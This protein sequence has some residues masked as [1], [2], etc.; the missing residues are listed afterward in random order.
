MSNPINPAALER[1]EE[2]IH[3]VYI[4]I[5]CVLNHALDKSLPEELWIGAISKLSGI[6]EDK[7]KSV[8]KVCREKYLRRSM[9]MSS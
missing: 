3:E 9:G 4:V 2:E 7:V 8:F 6:S 5:G 1:A